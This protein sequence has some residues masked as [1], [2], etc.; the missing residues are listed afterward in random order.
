MRRSGGRPSDRDLI[1]GRRQLC[2]GDLDPNRRVEDL[3]YLNSM[4]A[5]LESRR[6]VEGRVP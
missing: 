5:L 4:V 3:H 1:E 2:I 6:V